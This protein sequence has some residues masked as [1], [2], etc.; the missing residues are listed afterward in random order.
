MKAYGQ[1]AGYAEQCL[2]SMK[3]VVAFGM[4]K[5]EIKNYGKYLEAGRRAGAVEKLASGA[6]LSLMMTMIYLVYA[7]SF[8]VGGKFVSDGVINRSTGEIY[9]FNDIIAIFF[10]VLIGLF[11]FSMAGPSF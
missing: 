10:G 9:A 8:W 5:V 1:S 11:G 6:G 2:S 3:V 4:E 7:Y